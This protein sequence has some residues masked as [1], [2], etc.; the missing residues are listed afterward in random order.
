MKVADKVKDVLAVGVGETTEDKKFTYEEVA[1][2]GACGL[3]P[4]MTIDDKTFG[5]LD[6]DKTRNIIESFGEEA[7]GG[8][9]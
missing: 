8:Q 9:A 6:P 4:V 7:E 2:I 3:A 1:C 5:K